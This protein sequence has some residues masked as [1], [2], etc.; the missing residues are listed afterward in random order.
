MTIRPAIAT[1]PRATVRL[2]APSGEQVEARV[3]RP[4]GKGPHPAVLLAH[5]FAAVKAGGL[6]PFAERFRR[7]GFTAIAFDYRQWGGSS[8]Q[9]RDEASV[10][11]QRE[12]YRTV[13]DWAIAQPDILFRSRGDHYGVYQGGEDFDRVI[14]TEVEFLHRHT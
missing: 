9:P 2:P 13:I 4:E 6:E 3:Y 12:D 7:E 8:G 14:N 1:S 10:P 5:G 11:R